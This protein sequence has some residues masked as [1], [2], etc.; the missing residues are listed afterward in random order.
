MLFNGWLH[1]ILL[2]SLTPSA[3]ILTTDGTGFPCASHFGEFESQ[4]SMIHF[5]VPS[6]KSEKNSAK[7]D[8]LVE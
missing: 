1:A 7:Y 4:R 3:D 6:G 8:L 5:S 2:S